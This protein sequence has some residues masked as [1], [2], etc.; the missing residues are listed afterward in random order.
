MESKD[1]QSDLVVMFFSC[2]FFI[3]VK[4][5]MEWVVLIFSLKLK[6]ILTKSFL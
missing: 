3:P 6:V 4:M 2:L 5:Q 1:H